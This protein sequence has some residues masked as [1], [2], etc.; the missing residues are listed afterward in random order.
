MTSSCKKILSEMLHAKALG[1]A[2]WSYEKVHR[3]N[4][5]IAVQKLKHSVSKC[6]HKCCFFKKKKKEVRKEGRGKGK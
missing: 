6:T 2:A 5:M 3:K 1:Q 4:Q